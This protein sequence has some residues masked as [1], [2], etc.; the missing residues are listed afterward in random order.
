MFQND[1]PAQKL[2]PGIEYKVGKRVSGLLTGFLSARLVLSALTS[3]DF[4]MSHRATTSSDRYGQETSG[5]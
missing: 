3:H 1:S 4:Q 2:R 5:E